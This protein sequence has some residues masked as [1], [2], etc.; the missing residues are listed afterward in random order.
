MPHRKVFWGNKSANE[1]TSCFGL[2]KCFHS[3]NDPSFKAAITQK[4]SKSPGIQYNLHCAW[5]PKFSGR[6]EKIN[7][8][9]KIQLRK[10]SQVTHFP[11]VTLLPMT[12]LWVRNTPSKLG[13]RHFKRLHG[14][15]FFTNDFLLDQETSKLVKHVTS[16]THFQQELT[17]LA[18]AQPQETGP[19]LFN[20]GDLILV[21]ALPCLSPSLSLSW[22]GPY[23][24]LSTPSTVKEEST[25]RY[26]TFQ[27]KPWKLKEHTWM[28]QRNILDINVKRG[29]LKLKLIKDK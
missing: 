9:I 24:V 19:A 28:A 22:E 11:Q 2:P 27:S 1:I 13:L 12:L 20:T 18:E 14:W 23:T 29:N 25:P 26:I 21:K 10:L 5:R 4:V 7:D 17:Q 6:V 15:L 16:Q 8:V 3:E